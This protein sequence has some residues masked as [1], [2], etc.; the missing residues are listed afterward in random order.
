MNYL[1]LYIENDKVNDVRKYGMKLSEYA[2][3]IITVDAEKKGIV[4]YLTPKDSIAYDDENYTCLK[5]KTTNLHVFIY[6]KIFE[7][8]DELKKYFLDINKYQFGSYE[9]PTA[10]ICSTILPE[11]IE[12]Y[13]KILDYPN[14]IENSKEYYYEKNILD[15]LESNLFTNYE[16]Y[17][18]LL[19]LGQQKKVFD[20]NN[21]TDKIKIF[22]N[23]VNNK[24]YTKKNNF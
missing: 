9:T 3:K 4:A 20:T 6:N 5:I 17:Q 22:T 8:T 15:M 23:K 24:T 11:N 14:L 10:L 12:L 1:Y 19:I 7:G 21:I 2:N 16:I 18:M 13:N